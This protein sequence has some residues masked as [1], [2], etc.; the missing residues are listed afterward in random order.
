MNTDEMKPGEVR[1]FQKR[2]SLVLAIGVWPKR[3][4]KQLHIDITGTKDFHT[5]VTCDA[6]SERYHRTLFR[7]LRRVLI[8]NDCWSFGD[9]G[10]ET[11]HPDNSTEKVAR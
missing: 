4:G 1:V 11:E 2:G 6:K 3:R 7:D 9:E 10:A 5:T 8:A